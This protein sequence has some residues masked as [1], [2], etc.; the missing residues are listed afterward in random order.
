MDI[1]KK[2]IEVKKEEVTLLKNNFSFSLLQSM[3]G[4]E[5]NSNQFSQKINR[6]SEISIIAEIKKASPSKGIIKEYFNHI[7]IASEYIQNEVAAISILTDKQFFN[8][9][10][11]YLSD[12]SK[13]SLLPLLRKDFIID[14]LQVF[15]SKAYGADF[16]LLISEILSATQ[17]SELTEAASECG[18]EVL[19]ELHS[20]KELDKIDFNHNSL[21]GINNRDLKSFDVD[22]N[23]TVRISRLIPENSLIVS[24]SGISGRNH[25]DQLKQ[26]NLSAILIGEHFMRSQNISSS[27]TEM[28]E[29]CKR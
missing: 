27:I 28:K 19:L 26:I 14:A 25:L 1:L 20:E 10:L 8:G 2:I 22:L 17:I 7:E 16:I 9:D 5:K 18:L 21:I 4:F 23:T 15:E 3:E 24:E 12:V 11:K 29:W 13:L 6:N